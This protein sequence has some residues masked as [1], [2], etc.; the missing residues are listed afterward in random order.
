MPCG[1]RTVKPWPSRLGRRVP[2]NIRSMCVTWIRRWRRRSLT[3]P[4]MQFPY[5]GP[6]PAGSFSGPRKLRQDSGRFPRWV[7]NLNRCRLSTILLLLRYPVRHGS[8]LAARRRRWSHKYLDQFT[9]RRGSYAIRAGPFAS[10]T[11]LNT[12]TVKYSPDGKQI[13]FI[14][15]A[16]ASEEAWLL[17]YP[18]NASNPPRRIL[19]ACRPLR[20]RPTFRG[21]RITAALCSLAHRVGN[22]D[23]SIWRIRSR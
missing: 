3:S 18:A 6:R 11:V 13:I 15:N 21:C 1:H 16:G 23:N 5:S 12:P 8:G 20:T 10:R 9:S 19:E 2:T 4:R 7:A 14:R 22:L 17:P